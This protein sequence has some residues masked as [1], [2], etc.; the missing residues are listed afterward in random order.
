MPN[1]R[2]R[3]TAVSAFFRR[4][5]KV[6][7]VP[8]RKKRSDVTSA[9][10]VTSPVPRI[11]EEGGGLGEVNKEAIQRHVV[12]DR[13]TAARRAAKHFGERM[14]LHLD[15]LDRGQRDRGV[16]RRAG[17]AGTEHLELQRLAQSSAAAE[18][19]ERVG[20]PVLP[21]PPAHRL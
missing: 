4:I 8:S 18:D 17:G 16:A 6:T 2:S 7:S 3:W 20:R 15:A 9:S 19:G 11:R 10:S 13:E 1:S 12:G 5:R 14:R 21:R